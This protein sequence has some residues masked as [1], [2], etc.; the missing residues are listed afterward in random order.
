MRGS[1]LARVDEKGRLKIPADF[2]AEL[3]QEDGEEFFVTSYDGQFTRMYPLREW[4]RI[5]ERLAATGSMDQVKRKFLNLVN[6]YGQVVTMDKQGR[7]LIPALLRESAA[8]KG[9]VM[10]LGQTNFLDVW[11]RQRLVDDMRKSQ[12]TADEKNQLGQMGV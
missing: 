6:Y 9:E 12:L 11:N 5:E 2:L 7:V 10:V 3:R 8:M 4:K 1:H